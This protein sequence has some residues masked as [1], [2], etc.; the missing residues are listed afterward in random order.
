MDEATPGSDQACCSRT[1]PQAP[2]SRAALRALVGCL[3]LAP[4]LL[5]GRNCW[6]QQLAPV[7][8][9]KTA[10][11][12]PFRLTGVEGYIQT[13]YLRDENV[14]SNSA[15]GPRSAIGL[16]QKQSTMREE[17][18]VMTHSYV[19]H[20][21]LLTLDVGGGPILD[22][23]SYTTESSSTDA[24]KPLYNFTGRATF[25][26]D[27][28]YRGALF[29]EHLNPTQSVGPAQV[30]LNENTRYGG[31]FSLLSPVTPLPVHVDAARSTSQGR[32]ALQTVDDRIDQFSLR[33]ER[34]LGTLGDTRFQYQAFRQESSSGSTGL[35]I[36][37]SRSNNDVFSLDT[38]L[39]FGASGQ[40]DVNNFITYRAQ[41]YATGQSANV[42]FKDF[43]FLTNVLGRHSDAL[44]TFGTYTFNTSHQ[45]NQA[46]TLNSL[47][48]GINYRM[49]PDLYSSLG[50]RA[51]HNRSARFT[52][53]YSGINGS[54]TYR[55]KLPLGVATAN[56][57][58]SYTVRDQ[59]AGGD[60]VRVI[61]EHATLVGATLV[62][63]GA[64]HVIPNTVIV[65]NL[66]RSQIFVEGIDYVLTTVGVETRIQRLIGGNI[67]EGQEVL[68]DYATSVGGTYTINQVDQGI[69][70]NWSPQRYYSL[71][72]RHFDSAPHLTSGTPTFQLNPSKSMT[73]GARADVPLSLLSE[74][75]TVGGYSEHEDRREVIAPYKR[76]Q[77]EAYAQTTVPLI[78]RGGIRV[79]T[80][81]T[82][83]DYD[84]NPAYGVNLVGHDARFWSRLPY[85]IELSV[86]ARW[87]RDTGAVI[88]RES[89]YATA[90]AS[91][92]YRSFLTTFDLTRLHDTQGTT[93]RTRT[94]GQLLLR[95]NFR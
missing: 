38:R 72:L 69:N 9:K 32:S 27:K 28:P 79:G 58:F 42:D 90:K 55:R 82:R 51:D 91:W 39:K 70:L 37:T 29:Y 36:Q 43:R 23:S 24:S 75:A 15:T 76:Q 21:G 62:K 22:R 56:Y 4:A 89:T 53:T 57:T 18:F 85:G 5:L 6:A 2:R 94:R 67:L 14:T 40:Y 33:S 71:Y 8:V 30:M 50:A 88:P 95:R 83:I 45:G 49:S 1:W 59:K 46:I 48:A 44:Q 93:E 7:A 92:R 31:N 19:Y 65:S 13:R 64:Q 12:A 41:T 61:G 73:Y 17:I 16:R 87:E 74:Q 78:S 84:L 20:P 80:R 26:R 35:P 81:H 11:I 52:S 34:R 10:E 86:D 25:L 3:A 47:N 60:Q 68:V 54:A 66:T 77:Y 63:L